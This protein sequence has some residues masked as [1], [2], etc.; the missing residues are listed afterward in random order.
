[1]PVKWPTKYSKTTNR[2][3][4]WAALKNKHA[5]AIK[6][7]KIDFD[8]RLG[9]AV[10]QFENRIKLVATAGYGA[11][12]TLQDLEKVSQAGLSASQVADS[13]KSKLSRLPDPA[14]KELTAFLTE[15]ENDAQMWA[16]ATL[17]EPEANIRWKTMEWNACAALAGHVEI[18]IRRGEKALEALAAH[19][20]IG[21][22]DFLQGLQTHLKELHQAAIA[23]EPSAKHLEAMLDNASRNST[24][25]GVLKGETAKALAGPFAALS[26]RIQAL[27]TYLTANPFAGV[28]V[29]QGA[30]TEVRA[31]SK[32]VEFVKTDLANVAK[33]EKGLVL[34]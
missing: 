18:M 4:E 10:D 3:N 5:A 13:Y 34:S 33:A 26:Q 7:A 1:M 19:P 32:A 24:L 9:S 29:N 12:A 27:E 22:A 15:I 8:A 11:K 21:S 31:V 25:L 30:D 2:H 20:N 28:Y 16:D 6:A 23:A 14:K 17:F